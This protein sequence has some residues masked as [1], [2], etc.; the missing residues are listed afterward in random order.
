MHILSA[1]TDGPGRK[2]IQTSE[3]PSYEIKHLTWCN[4]SRYRSALHLIFNC[5]NTDVVLHT[6]AQVFQ[7]AGVLTSFHK[8]LHTVS[9]LSVSGS[10]CHFVPGDVLEG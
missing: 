5:D 2:P 4:D 1:W 3:R 7:S 8:F 10:A 9:L 6:R